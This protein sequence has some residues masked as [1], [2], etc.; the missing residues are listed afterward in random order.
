MHISSLL[1]LALGAIALAQPTNNTTD[2]SVIE[3]RSSRPWIESF[4]TDDTECKIDDGGVRPFIVAGDCQPFYP[5]YLR[6][7]GSWGAGTY[8]LSSFTT[9]ENDDC[10]GP[11]KATINRKG[12]EHGFCF[13]LHTL[14]CQNG[15]V[16]N[17]CFWNG[18]RGNK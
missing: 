7:G 11:V 6:V 13:D 3:K 17:P 15:D 8:G 2:T 5:Y 12:K 16:D 18:I 1:F 14:G 10:T 4:D 9:Y